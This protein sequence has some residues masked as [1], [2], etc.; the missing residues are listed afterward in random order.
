VAFEARGS[1]MVKTLDGRMRSRYVLACAREEVSD[2]KYPAN[3]RLCCGHV[4]IGR[5]KRATRWG[6]AIR[7]TMRQVC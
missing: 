6:S 5:S 7:F 4:G 3:L 2:E 1:A